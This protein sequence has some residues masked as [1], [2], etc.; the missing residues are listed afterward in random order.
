MSIKDIEALLQSRGRGVGVYVK[1]KHSPETLAKISALHK[2]KTPWNK[3]VKDCQVAWN[4]GLHDVQ[5]NSYK[6]RPVKTPFGVFDSVADAGK[7]LGHKSG[8]VVQRRIKKRV[9]GYAYA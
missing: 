2:G 6:K 1:H 4:K 5:D 8:S 9:P 7:A 3:G